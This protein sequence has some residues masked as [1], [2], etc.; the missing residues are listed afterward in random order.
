HQIDSISFMGMGEALANRKVF[1]A[2]DSF[3][4][5]NL[6]ALSPRRLSISTI[7][8]IPSIKKITQEYPQVNLTFS[9]HSPYSEERSK[10]MPINDRYPID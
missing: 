8:I 2:L 1:D 7:G 4:D 5:P 3:T 6:F 10:L 9:L